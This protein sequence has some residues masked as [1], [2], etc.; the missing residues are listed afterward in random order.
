MSNSGITVGE[1]M[2]LAFELSALD[3]LADPAEV[4]ADARQWSRY[5]GIISN[6]TDAVESYVREHDLEPDF[7]LGGRDK[8]LAS[9]EIRQET[10]TERHVFVGAG[11]EDRRIAEHTGWEFV[12]I[13]DAAEK[14]GWTLES[15]RTKQGLLERLRGWLS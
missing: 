15:E 9:S 8:W 2:T 14:A 3:R 10:G 1:G 6:D 13:T 12:P 7:D 11:T 5:V 4:F